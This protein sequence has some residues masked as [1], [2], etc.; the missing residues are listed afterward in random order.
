MAR[1]EQMWLPGFGPMQPDPSEL[2]SGA[3]VIVRAYSYDASDDDVMV[4]DGVDG[5]KEAQWQCEIREDPVN[6]PRHYTRGGIEC[7]DALDAAVTG[8]PPDEAICVANIIKYV[9]RYRDKTPVESLK[10]AR[11]YLD[12]LIGKV[13]GRY[14]TCHAGRAS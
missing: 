11:W 13:D 8:C 2:P 14:E 7:I 6:H 4:S 9:W 3:G 1:Y 10:K 5:V 12:R